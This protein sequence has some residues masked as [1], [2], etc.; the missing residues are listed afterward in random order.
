M[1][2]PLDRRGINK[3]QEELPLLKNQS[4]WGGYGWTGHDTAPYQKYYFSGNDVFVFIE[5]Y[6]QTRLIPIPITDMGYGI[7]QEKVPIFGY[8]SYT[9]DTVARGTRIIR[10]EFTIV[11]T[12]VNFLGRLLG[13][14]SVPDVTQEDIIHPVVLVDE[15]D[16][17]ARRKDL[18]SSIWG[19]KEGGTVYQNATNINSVLY[20]PTKVQNLG[21]DGEA[22]YPFG[23]KASDG[24]S[25]AEFAGHPPFN[26]VVAFG[27]NPSV[28]E[29]GYSGFNYEQWKLTAL[30]DYKMALDI[31]ESQ[32]VGERVILKNVEL[33][34]CGTVLDPSGQPL[35]ESY[36]FI[37][38]DATIPTVIR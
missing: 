11:F 19:Y 27:D 32:N 10:G 8:S 2:L 26:I 30:D 25:E 7:S 24:Y 31:N 5:P 37:A 17:L 3:W 33:M 38:R 14:P 29:I 1:V 34:S 9:W 15:D 20:D 13:D 36:S 28:R 22:A 4:P 23:R 16:E 12:K 21:D 18:R 6:G 35:R